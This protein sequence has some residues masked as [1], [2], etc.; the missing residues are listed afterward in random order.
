M[1]CLL[2]T[3]KMMVNA[4]WPYNQWVNIQHS[5][6][7]FFFQCFFFVFPLN[8]FT[9]SSCLH[10]CS[11]FYISF[12]F[13]I[14][15]NFS[16]ALSKVM[17]VWTLEFQI[18]SQ[19]PTTKENNFRQLPC[20]FLFLSFPPIL[21]IFLHARHLLINVSSLKLIY[22]ITTTFCVHCTTMW[23]HF[24]SS[25][26]MNTSNFIF[27]LFYIP[28]LSTL[29]I[30]TPFRSPCMAFVDY[31][32]SF[33]DCGNTFANCTKTFVD[34]ANKFGNYANTFDDVANT[35]NITTLRW[36]HTKVEYFSTYVES[37]LH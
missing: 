19:L 21:F 27:W 3:L 8:N 7:L 36:K 5:I 34:Y 18:C 31:I 28:N 26:W 6:T 11:L 13:A 37:I 35:P 10:L 20:L 12:S 30:W 2:H 9:S 22:P 16:I 23:K 25:L 32:N 15:C 33:V 14:L 4:M 17:L 29:I 1:L 24:M